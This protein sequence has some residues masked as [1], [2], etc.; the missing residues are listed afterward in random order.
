MAVKG[1]LKLALDI[2]W[3]W[4]A[5]SVIRAVY[6]PSHYYWVTIN[7]V[8]QASR[9][10]CATMNPILTSPKGLFSTGLV[11]LAE[12]LSLSLI[13]INFHQ[14]ALAE[15]LAE[16]Q[17]A[18]R[19]L[20]RLSRSPFLRKTR[21]NNPFTYGGP[22]TTDVNMG[23]QPV[24][25][26]PTPYHPHSKSLPSKIKRAKKTVTNVIVDQVRIWGLWSDYLTVV[27]SGKPLGRL[28]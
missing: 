12:K 16:N 26:E 4:V 10:Y 2:T 17:L 14:Q 21:R 20:D 24:R 1:W 19:A 28:R 5:L 6:R 27:R 7:Q 23:H 22:S 9:L 18:L 13:S 25:S 15:R 3:A 8:M 11:F